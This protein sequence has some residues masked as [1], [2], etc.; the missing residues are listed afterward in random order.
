MSKHTPFDE[1]M[2]ALSNAKADTDY[3]MHLLAELVQLASI[4][5]RPEDVLRQY[6][7]LLGMFLEHLAR[8]DQEDDTDPYAFLRHF[9]L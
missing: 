4:Q 9:K 2:T 3:A 7:R 1:A 8:Q 5:E 6:H